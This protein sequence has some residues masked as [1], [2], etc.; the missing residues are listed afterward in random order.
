MITFKEL[1]YVTLVNKHKNFSLAAKHAGIS[2]P[3]LSMA[4]SKLEEKLDLV[5]FYRDTNGMVRSNI[6]SEFLSDEGAHIIKD[7]DDIIYLS[8][9]L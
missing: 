2:Q 6:Y 4:I 8:V 3:A 1:K 9:R 5:L 7:V